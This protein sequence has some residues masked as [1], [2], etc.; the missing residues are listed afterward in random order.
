[1]AP[2]LRHATAGLR[3]REVN[4]YQ[5][6]PVTNDGQDP[7]RRPQWRGERRAVL[8]RLPVTVAA[9]LQDRA[10]AHGKSLSDAAGELISGGL[11]ADWHRGTR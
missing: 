4:V 3:G 9:E 11:S 8:V 6:W 2:G 1:M 5:D 7:A 10:R